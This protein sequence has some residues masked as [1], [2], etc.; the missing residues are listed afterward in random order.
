[1]RGIVI[2][3]Q[4]LKDTCYKALLYVVALIQSLQLK[5]IGAY[6][7]TLVIQSVVSIKNLFAQT[8]L[9]IKVWLAPY[10]IIVGLLIRTGLI[11]VLRTL[12]HLGSK[13]VTTAHQILQRVKQA[14][15]LGN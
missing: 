8:L 10:L 14:W 1:M 7:I 6:L 9:K 3:L 15:R 13:L 5:T 12:G 4:Q 11:V 2:T